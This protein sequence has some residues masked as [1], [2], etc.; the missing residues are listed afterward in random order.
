MQRLQFV[1]Y[2]GNVLE[3]LQRLLNIHFQHI[4]NRLTL[5]SDLQRFVVVPVSFADRTGNPHVSQKIHLQS[6]GP[7]TLTRFAT[8]TLHIE[9]ETARFVAAQLR[10]R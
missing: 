7:I 6:I 1:L 3:Q 2:F 9:T 10:F 8:S 5:E 4:G